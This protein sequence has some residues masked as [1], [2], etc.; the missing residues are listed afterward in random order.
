MHFLGHQNVLPTYLGSE[1]VTKG[2]Y[3]FSFHLKTITKIA[4]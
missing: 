2:A 4:R 3:K 1:E